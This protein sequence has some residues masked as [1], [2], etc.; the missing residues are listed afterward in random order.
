MTWSLIFAVVA[1]SIYSLIL[2]FSNEDLYR[3]S[4]ALLKSLENEIRI[5][6]RISK[7]TGGSYALVSTLDDESSPFVLC[8]DTPEH[9]KSAGITHL[10]LNH[11]EMCSEYV[12]DEDL[13]TN[14]NDSFGSSEWLFVCGLNSQM[15]PEHEEGTE[16]RNV[17]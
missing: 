3:N 5:N 4:Q 9:A 16:S 15:Q 12:D 1:L 6:Q 14:R 10:R 11:P 13:W 8:F 17:E 7:Y 2:R